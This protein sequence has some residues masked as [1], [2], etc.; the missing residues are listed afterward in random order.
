MHSKTFQDLNKKLHEA[1]KHAVNQN[2][3]EVHEKVKGLYD[4]EN[5]MED[6]EN[7]D[8]KTQQQIHNSTK[9]R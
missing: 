2:L 6:T 5:I 4:K 8:K 9:T 1:T 3:K 7:N